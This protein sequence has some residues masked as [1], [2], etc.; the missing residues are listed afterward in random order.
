MARQKRVNECGHPERPHHAHGMCRSCECAA[1]NATHRE[2]LNASKRSYNM[3]HR[4]ELNA[5]K[6]AYRAA[7][8]EEHS[9]ADRARYVAH[10]EERLA[11][12]VIYNAAHREERRATSRARYV[13]H[14][15]EHRAAD[16]ARNAMYHTLDPD[17]LGPSQA[18]CLAR[19]E[20]ITA[21]ALLLTEHFAE[22]SQIERWRE[23]LRNWREI[24]RSEAPQAGGV[25]AMVDARGFLK[26]GNASNNVRARLRFYRIYSAKPP[27]LLAVI[28]SIDELAAHDLLRPWMVADEWFVPS[29]EAFERLSPHV[30]AE[31]RNRFDA[32]R[33][34]L[35]PSSVA[36]T[37]VERCRSLVRLSRE[38]LMLDAP[39]VDGVYCVATSDGLLKIG[40]ASHIN[41]RMRQYCTHAALAP[42]YLATLPGTEAEHHHA[43][44]S[45][46]L[47]GEYF[48]PSREVLEYV[49]RVAF[50]TCAPTAADPE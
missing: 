39:A 11:A 29:T 40:K 47:A 5:A 3:K 21:A 31:W 49:R 17:T 42:A 14:R 25:Y 37:D 45:W 30:P 16:R 13:A 32:R 28:S 15:E 33:A 43:L 44:R 24:G 26:V 18:R 4:E 50:G 34:A 10:R 8:R 35:V 46:R 1:Y 41:W 23:L 27:A 12:K 6:R 38:M 2:E 9:A 36:N 48:A 7:H 19:F 20:Q 22:A